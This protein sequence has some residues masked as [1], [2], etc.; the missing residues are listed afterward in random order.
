MEE[1]SR[2]EELLNIDPDKL[3]LLGH[4]TRAIAMAMIRSAIDMMIHSDLKVCAESKSES[5]QAFAKHMNPLVK[6]WD[7]DE[8]NN[9]FAGAFHVF[10]QEPSDSRMV[11]IEDVL[12]MIYASVHEFSSGTEVAKEISMDGFGNAKGDDD[13]GPEL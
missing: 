4:Q 7:T 11:T 5:A 8:M 12:K 6:D 13:A 10:S 2:T 9:V 1:T 3:Q